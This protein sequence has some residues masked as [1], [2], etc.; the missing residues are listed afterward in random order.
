MGTDLG[1]STVSKPARPARPVKA[2][3]LTAVVTFVATALGQHVIGRLADEAAAPFTPEV[4]IEMTTPLNVDGSVVVPPATTIPKDA[5]SQDPGLV[6]RWAVNNGG[7]PANCLS[8]G[9]TVWGNVDRPIILS[10]V[11]ATNVHCQAAPAWTYIHTWGGGDIAERRL[12]I[13]LD[14]G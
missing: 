5:V 9:L 4:G 14:F 12:N 1:A 2:I 11:R 10:G 7:G 13:N 8:I 6:H 3:T